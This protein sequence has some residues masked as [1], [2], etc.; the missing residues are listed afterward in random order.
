MLRALVITLAV[1]AGAKI[2]AQE[3]LYR[4][5]AQEALIRA[6]RERAIAACQSA[7]ALTPTGGASPL[8]TRP[9]SVDLAIGRSNVDVQIWQLSSERW[10]ARFRHPHVVLTL[11]GGA[12][13]P[14]CEFDVIEERAYV[15]QM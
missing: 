11:G 6:Y 10:P 13:S 2:W 1:L 14:V 5:G 7:Q 4:D 8:W 15:T 9:A 12:P 3:R